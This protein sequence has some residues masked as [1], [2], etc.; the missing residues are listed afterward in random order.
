MDFF[1]VGVLENSYLKIAP[2]V[3]HFDNYTRPIM[4]YLYQNKLFMFNEK[5]RVLS[6]KCLSIISLYDIK[7]TNNSILP[8]LVEKS[9][10]SNL[11]E[12]HGAVLGISYILQ[13]ICGDQSYLKDVN[14]DNVFY[15]TLHIND[16]KLLENGEY[17]V[18]FK[19]YLQ[20]LQSNN[21]IQ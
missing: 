16:R 9:R 10:S 21:Y 19:K 6:A 4:D 20:S 5:I 18:Q 3:A 2:F 17:M 14:D 7:Y 15:Q 1:T 13:S 12:R 11:Y 8:Y